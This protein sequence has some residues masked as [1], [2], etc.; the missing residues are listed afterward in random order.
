LEE[1]NENLSELEA[2]SDRFDGKAAKAVL[3]RG[4][5]RQVWGKS[6]KSCPNQRQLQTALGEINE[7]L[8]ELE[9]SS[10]RFDGKAAKAVRT[11]GIFRQV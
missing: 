6:S 7:K 3:T 1:I 10:D 8:S 4:I 11:K 5:F 2:P 9:A